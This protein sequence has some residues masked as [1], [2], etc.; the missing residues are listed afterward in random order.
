[1]EFAILFLVVIA[2][3]IGLLLWTRRNKNLGDP[4]TDPLAHRNL[5]SG[6]AGPPRHAQAGQ[7]DLSGSGG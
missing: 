1:M 4:R 5:G 6:N 2:V 3:P 7:G